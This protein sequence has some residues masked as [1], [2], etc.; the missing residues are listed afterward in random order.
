MNYFDNKH[1][2]HPYTKIPSDNPSYLVKSAKGVYLHLENGQ[3]VIDGMSSW[4]AAIH[5]YNNEVLNKAVKA[6]L[7]N[8]SHVMFGGITHK[9]A[10]NLAK[11]LI[12]ITPDNLTKI[13][14]AD[15]GSVSVEVALKIALQF[16]QSKNKPNKQKFIT[17]TSGYHGDTFAAMSVCDPENGM[18][19][20][21]KGILLKNFFVK[22]PS[23]FPTDDAIKDLELTLSKNHHKIAAMILEPIVQGAGGMQIYDSS[24]LIKARELCDKYNVLLILD[25][26]ATGFGRTGELFAL[27]HANIKPDILCLGKAITGGYISFAA[28]MTTTNIANQV[29]VLMHGPT[30]MANPLACAVA[31]SSIELLLNTAWQD[32]VK[33]IENT[34]KTEL[35]SLKNHN[36]VK[37]VRVLG[38]IAVVEM[39]NNVCI[40]TVQKD[41]INNGVWLRPYNNLIYTMPPFI[42]TNSELLTITRAIKSVI[43]K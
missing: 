19:H 26:I 17:I 18:H 39:K 37:D 43:N 31:N 24:Y 25:E 33:N 27:Q 38:A 3:N 16:W 28:T 5:G 22:S 21:F 12:N 20:L 35:M 13:F 4:W 32:N 42:I 34:L 8:M 1:I 14:F 15:S 7:K 41:L 2:W 6:Q 23:L 10:I 30:F 11:T 29:G 36:K 40:N 9:P